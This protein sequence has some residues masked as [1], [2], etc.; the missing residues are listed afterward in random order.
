MEQTGLSPEPISPG[1]AAPAPWRA[2]DPLPGS[3][4]TARLTLRF[5][6]P[7]DAAAML[8]AI[9]IDRGAFLPWLP[10]VREDN[11]TVE[12]CASA[13]ERQRGKRERT[14]PPADDFTI[15][16]FERASGA[17]IGGT[18]LHRVNHAAHE[19]EIGYWVRADRRREGL[20]AEA[21]AG[22]ITWAFAR[23][24]A[25]GWG[26][27]R[28]HIRC[29]GGNEASQRVPTKLGLRMEGRLRKDR[30]VDGRGWDD[31]LIWG[32]LVGEWDA[33]R[34]VPKGPGLI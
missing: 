11:R 2:P 16:I 27:R 22:L 30:W 29:A 1:A 13:I 23:A 4:D 20:C 10:W 31:T 3:F 17:V 25:G 9:D 8:A 5:W 6:K 24:E 12:E 26:L 33:V 15:A 32:V 7:P 14:D 18:G 21:V 28:I 19:A 34:H